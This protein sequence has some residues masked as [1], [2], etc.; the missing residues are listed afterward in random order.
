MSLGGYMPFKKRQK[1]N[2]GFLNKVST[3]KSNFLL[4]TGGKNYCDLNVLK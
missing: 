1:H 4:A 2:N 3:L